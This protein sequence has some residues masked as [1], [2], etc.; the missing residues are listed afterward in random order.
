MGAPP[1]NLNV[2]LKREEKGSDEPGQEN[3]FMQ[4]QKSDNRCIRK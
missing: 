3:A 2:D 4:P 1:M